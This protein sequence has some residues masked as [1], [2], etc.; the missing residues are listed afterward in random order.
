MGLQRVRHDWSNWAKNDGSDWAH[1]RVE[2]N[3]V[4]YFGF[5]IFKR[6]SKQFPYI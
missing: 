5:L 4:T 6:D 3:N 2:D 1:R